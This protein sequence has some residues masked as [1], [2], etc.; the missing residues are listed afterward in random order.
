MANLS[1]TAANVIASSSAVIRREYKAGATITAGQLVYLDANSVWQLVDSDAAATGNAV[2]DLRG[3]ALNGAAANQP[4]SV[5]TQDLGGFTVGATLTNGTTY[6]ASTT[7]GAIANDVPTTN[8]Y[9]TIVGVARSAAL[10]VLNPT[11]SG[12]VI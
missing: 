4:L 3:I 2:N 6:Y 1:I 11:A 12:V 5:C 8:A 10:L 9:P 7:A